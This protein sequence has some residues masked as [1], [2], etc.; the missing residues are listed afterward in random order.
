MKHKI[1]EKR[2]LVMCY[3]NGES[4]AHICTEAGIARST[5]YSWVM[6]FQTTV[7]EAGTLVTPQAFDA[8]RRKLRSRQLSSRSLIA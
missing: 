1:E 2:R 4:A 6:P 3:Q 7:T 5:F 8:L